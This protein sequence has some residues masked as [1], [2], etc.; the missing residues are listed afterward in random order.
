[1]IQLVSHYPYKHGQ[2]AVRWVARGS[3]GEGRTHCLCEGDDSGLGDG[4]YTR[5][6]QSD[7]QAEWIW[8]T[9]TQVPTILSLLRSIKAAWF[10]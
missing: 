5:D 4:W 2:G 7:T 1:M 6:M 3:N 10:R 9:V 8:G